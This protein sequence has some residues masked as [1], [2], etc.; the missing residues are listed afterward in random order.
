[1]GAER[2]SGILRCAGGQVAHLIAAAGGVG[3]H[4]ELQGVLH[5]LRRVASPELEDAASRRGELVQLFDHRKVQLAVQLT[6]RR[7]VGGVYA[8]YKMLGRRACG[9]CVL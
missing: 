3:G 7:A 1:M 2:V 4:E 8:A 5:L 9:T 6:A